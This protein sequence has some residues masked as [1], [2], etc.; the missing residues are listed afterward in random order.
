MGFKLRYRARSVSDTRDME[1]TQ[2]LLGRVNDTKGCVG[3]ELFR[4]CKRGAMAG[5]SNH[6]Q[7]I[8]QASFSRPPAST[9]PSP[10]PFLPPPF[11][12]P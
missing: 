1:T 10:P 2:T 12:L 8:A 7:R 5:T 9:S 6:H 3:C 11:H 4:L